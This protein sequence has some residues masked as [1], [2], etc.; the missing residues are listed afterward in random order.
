MRGVAESIVKKKELMKNPPKPQYIARQELRRKINQFEK[1]KRD[2][3]KP[4][5]LWDY[6]RSLNKSYKESLKAKRAGKDVA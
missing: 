5:P 2:A 1:Q 4:S 6:D 3:R